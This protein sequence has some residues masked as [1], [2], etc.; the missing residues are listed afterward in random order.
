MQLAKSL[1]FAVGNMVGAAKV[2][3]PIE[4]NN[5]TSTSTNEKSF[6]VWFIIILLL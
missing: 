5:V 1:I 6:I 4:L 3:V 2:G